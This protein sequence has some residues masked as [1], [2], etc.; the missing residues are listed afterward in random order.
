MEVCDSFFFTMSNLV[1]NTLNLQL[2]LKFAIQT[3]MWEFFMEL[4]CIDVTDWT[5]WSLGDQVDIDDM[6]DAYKKDDGAEDSKDGLAIPN[7]SL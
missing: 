1:Q 2:L 4:F 5:D 6:L 7:V 3:S